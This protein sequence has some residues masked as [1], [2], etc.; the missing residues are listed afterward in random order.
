MP[1]EFCCDAEAD[2][3]KAAAAHIPAGRLYVS[4]HAGGHGYA[5][6]RYWSDPECVA[7]V[8]GL[9]EAAMC[10]SRFV[11]DRKR[12]YQ[13]VERWNRLFASF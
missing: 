2:A 13:L 7:A 11:R 6:E 4:G 12:A 1:A 3:V 9:L 8:P 5:I 10:A